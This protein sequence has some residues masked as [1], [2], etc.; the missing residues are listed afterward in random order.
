MYDTKVNVV[1]TSMTYVCEHSVDVTIYTQPSA[2]LHRVTVHSLHVLLYP[3][4]DVNVTLPATT[5]PRGEHL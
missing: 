3:L 1:V 5:A 4:N 2:R